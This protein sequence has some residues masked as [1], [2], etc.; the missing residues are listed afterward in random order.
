MSIAKLILTSPK[1]KVVVLVVL[2]RDELEY[3]GLVDDETMIMPGMRMGSGS[4]YLGVV[5]PVTKHRREAII[6]ALIEEKVDFSSVIQHDT[7]G[8]PLQLRLTAALARNMNGLTDT[9]ATVTGVAGVENQTRPVRA[10]SKRRSQ[11]TPSSSTFSPCKRQPMLKRETVSSTPFPELQ[12]DTDKKIVASCYAG[13]EEETFLFNDCVVLEEEDEQICVIF[14]TVAVPLVPAIPCRNDEEEVT[15]QSS[16]SFDE[17]A[18]VGS[19]EE[20]LDCDATFQQCKGLEEESV[21][22]INC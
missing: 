9:P 17:D 13:V 21:F 10:C 7:S 14:P 11:D 22:L 1:L 15:Q 19:Y 20:G 6:E 5:I 12:D 16:G 3:C 18:T 4:A 8:N 2:K